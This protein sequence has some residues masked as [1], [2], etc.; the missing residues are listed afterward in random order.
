MNTM[1]TSAATAPRRS[2]MDEFIRL[3]TEPAPLRGIG[4]ERAAIAAA[5]LAGEIAS[6]FALLPFAKVGM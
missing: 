3:T 5:G 1:Q 2:T 4:Y 6:V